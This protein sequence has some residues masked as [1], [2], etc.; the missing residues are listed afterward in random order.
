MRIVIPG[1]TGQLGHVLQRSFEARGHHVAILGRSV[2]D[3]A[4]RWDGRTDGPWMDV[5]D[6]ADAV[7][8]LTGRSVNCRYNWTNLNDMMNSRVDSALAVG[9][10]IAAAH[11]PP[12]VWIQASTGTIYAD[13][14]GAPHDEATGQLGGHEA[15]VPAYWGYSVNIARAWEMALAHSN[16]PHTRK[17][18]MRL[19]FVMSPDPGGVFDWLMWIVRHGLG[20]RFYGGGQSVSF[21]YDE[22]LLAALR[23]LLARED[24]EGPVNLAAPEPVTNAEFMATLRRAAGVPFG[25]PVLPGMAELGAV[26]LGTDVELMRKSRRFVPR[27]LLDAGFE[28]TAHDWA[29]AAPRLVARWEQLRESA[30]AA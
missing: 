28:F 5:I 1:G 22:D 16:T 20:G 18:A 25:L 29:D 15:H 30:L 2:A 17:V 23:F 6:G 4:L 11:N 19:G 8:Q 14:R 9:R 26:F 13:T 12:R 27:K 24:L 21:L 3:P 10:A 7:I